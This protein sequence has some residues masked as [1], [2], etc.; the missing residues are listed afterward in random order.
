MK[1]KIKKI[2]VP[3]DGSDRSLRGLKEGIYL[4]RQCSAVI[5]GLYVL[6]FYVAIT[7]PKF[8]GPYKNQLRGQAIDFLNRAK[9]IAAQNGVVFQEK[10]LE[11]DVTSDDVVNFA[12]SRGFDLVVIGSRGRSQVT[13][14][15]FGSVT[16]HLVHKSKIPVLVVK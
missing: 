8:L 14:F 2:L 16:N 9:T 12:N 11:G 15:L 1:R 6:P 13:G 10:I 5:T 3:L 4:A 7:G